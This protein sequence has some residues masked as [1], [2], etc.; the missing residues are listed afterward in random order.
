LA[1]TLTMMQQSAS[2]RV[3][4]MRPQRAAFEECR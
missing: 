2:E 3:S 1:P 4:S